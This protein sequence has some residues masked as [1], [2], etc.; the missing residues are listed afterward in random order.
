METIANVRT[1]SETHQRPV[2]LFAE[3]QSRL[4]PAPV[5]PY[6]IATVHTVRASSR[7]RVTWETNRYSVPAEYASTALTLKLYPE[8]LCIY[9]QDKLIARHARRYDRHQDIEDPDHPKALLAQ[10]RQAKAQ[11]LLGRFLTLSPRADAYYQA[12]EQ[13]RLNPQHHIQKIVAL[14]EIY[15]PEAVARAMADAFTFQAFSCEY[16]ANLL[17]QRQ[18]LLPEPGALHLTRRQDLLELDMPEPDLSLYGSEREDPEES[19]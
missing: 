4:P 14:S 2:D 17:E 11:K 9:H 5:Q 19:S 1:H 15:G 8:R 12:L 10:R 16:I 13:R 6:D 7:F 18:R 3:E